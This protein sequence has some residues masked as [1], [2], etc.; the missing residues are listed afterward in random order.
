MSHADAAAAAPPVAPRTVRNRLRSIGRA[1]VVT[2]GAVA[3][4][5]ALHVAVDAPAHLERG[6]LVH[7]RHATHVAVAGAAAPGAQDLDVPLVWEAH[8]TWE[9]VH[10]RPHERL[11]GG[12]R[13]AHL[14]DLRFM[15]RV[16]AADNL[17]TTEAGLH[18]GD[19]RLARDGHGAVTVQAG[20]LVLTGVDVVTEEDRLAGAL[21]PPRVAD[22]GSLVARR[23]LTGLC[24]GR[25][26]DRQCDRDTGPDPPTPLRHPERSM[27]NGIGLCCETACGRRNVAPAPN[28]A[29]ALHTKAL[30]RSCQQLMLQPNDGNERVDGVQVGELHPTP[31]HAAGHPTVADCLSRGTRQA[32]GHGELALL[33]LGEN[34]RAREPGLHGVEVAELAPTDLVHPDP[35]PGRTHEHHLLGDVAEGADAFARPLEP[36]RG[37]RRQ[38][39][40]RGLG[41]GTLARGGVE[42]GRPV[43]GRLMIDGDHD[44]V[45]CKRRVTER[46]RPASSRRAID[47]PGT[48][49]RP[50]RLMLSLITSAPR[51]N[52]RTLGS[53]SEG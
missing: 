2:H 29:Q 12:P 52:Q 48:A 22:D 7:L 28:G 19:P 8:E 36:L 13:L 27:A 44:V 24:R 32:V 41:L 37:A 10:A 18:R 15:G 14:L 47:T 20:D 5:V 53:T 43:P 33:G 46:K 23:R 40:E 51:P 17:M 3:R 34:E 21:Q 49:M 38:I 35:F 16:G 39:L 31:A 1:S 9:C 11:L 26:G 25:K 42:I 50:S 6:D 30:F 4:D 45:Y